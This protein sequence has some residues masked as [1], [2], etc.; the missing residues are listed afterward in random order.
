MGELSASNSDYGLSD[1]DFSD[2][3][4]IRKSLPA[5]DPRGSKIDTLL[6]SQPKPQPGSGTI[7]GQVGS[8]TSAPTGVLPWLRNLEGDIRHGTGTTAP[9]RALQF[10]GARGLES[11]TSQQAA[12]FVG[13]PILG[14]THVAQGIAQLPSSPWQGTKQI[15]GGALETAQIPSAFMG[16]P[17]I[18]EATRAAAYS[19]LPFV[20]KMLAS[21]GAAAEG[22][23]AA[24][25][26]AGKVPIQIT[27][28][29]SDATM[30]VKK[31]ADS[32]GQLPKVVNDFLKRTTDPSK[33]PLT[34]EE[35]RLFAQN[36]SRLSVD[37]MKRLT[38]ATKRLVGAF[39]GALNNS[40]Q[41]TAD[42]AGVGPRFEQAMQEFGQ[43]AQRNKK[44]SNIGTYLTR[45]AADK[46]PWLAIGYGAKQAYEKK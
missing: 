32:G 5:G 46:L 4:Q 10:L 3:Q 24:N 28:E 22:F 45:Q 35:A 33:P 44:I 2:L 12:D 26:A 23:Q 17:E 8:V 18:A 43:A 42:S 20:G 29:L 21:K 16:G 6:A 15:A 19:K 40:I 9:G 25:Q 39:H 38:P 36:A 7:G 1:Q 41:S 37:E 13:S 30:A 14:P 27:P 34:F 31:M 11:G